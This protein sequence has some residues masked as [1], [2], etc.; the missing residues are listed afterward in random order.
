MTEA[1][2]QIW[3]GPVTAS[4]VT[5]F[6]GVPPKVAVVAAARGADAWR[7]AA[8]VAR[9]D[10]GVAIMAVSSDAAELRV[11]RAVPREVAWVHSLADLEPSPLGLA[12][13]LAMAT[14]RWRS[15]EARL[16]EGRYRD[17]GRL[18]STASHEISNPLT[19]LLTNVEWVLKE[20]ASASSSRKELDLKAVLDAVREAY[21]GAKHVSRIAEDL[22]RVSRRA[23]RAVPVDVVKVLETSRRLLV[24]PLEGVRVRF[25]RRPLPVVRADETRLCQVFINL[26]KNAATALQGQPDPE[27]EIL[28]SHDDEEVVTLICDNGPGIDPALAR[29][30]F[31]EGVTGRRE[32][33]GLGLTISRRLVRDMGGSLQW[34]PARRGAAFRLALPICKDSLVVRPT[35]V[36]AHVR[37][38]ARVLLVDDTP[39]VGHALRRAL[40]QHVVTYCCDVRSAMEELDRE[41]FDVALVDLRMPHEGGI[42]FHQQVLSRHPKMGLRVVFLSGA[43]TDDDLAY[44]EEHQLRW[45]RKPVGA[46][47]LRNLVQELTADATNV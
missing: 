35:L 28:V 13:R 17:M 29:S 1:F 42:D 2:T 26:L 5:R 23:G 34:V 12:V 24:E 20:V 46:E 8:E 10:R 38:S 44:I 3:P 6:D 7:T 15:A 21:V 30:L 43:F 40:D 14:K 4:E 41:R 25:R 27:V 9:A 18:L 11:R 19:S 36:P 31:R 32:G 16:A 45:V 33:S 37:M 47:Q 22:G 39:M